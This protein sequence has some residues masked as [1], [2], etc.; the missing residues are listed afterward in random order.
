LEGAPDKAAFPTSLGSAVFDLRDIPPGKLLS[1]DISL[2]C[3]K[4]ID[5]STNRLAKIP[6]HQI[7]KGFLPER[8]TP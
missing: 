2:R 7:Y 1:L 6:R 3:Q 4:L 8:L 5:H